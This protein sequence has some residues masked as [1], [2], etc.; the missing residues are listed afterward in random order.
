MDALREK[1]NGDYELQLPPRREQGMHSVV[2]WR[3]ASVHSFFF[4]ALLPPSGGRRAI[5]DELLRDRNCKAVTTVLH[6]S[7]G[8]TWIRVEIARSPDAV[9]YQT[10][11]YHSSPMDN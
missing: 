5:R 7:R 11:S 10:S 6:V 2:A 1:E 8:T 3:H 4:F 9:D